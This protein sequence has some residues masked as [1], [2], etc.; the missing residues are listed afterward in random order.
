M[1][2]LNPY[3]NF[4]GTCEKAFNF[5]KSVFGGDFKGDIMRFGDINMEGMT[6]S[7]E[8][9]NLV[10]HISLPIGDEVLMG[11]DVFGAQSAGYRAGN[12]NYIS[13]SVDSREEADRLF[14]E[15]SAEGEVEMPMDDM[16]WGDY[17]GSFRDK[18]G[19]WWMI[20]CDTGRNME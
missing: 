3:L 7:D 8:E 19:I 16:F 11:S 9:R 4:N 2:K 15:L 17:Y 18:F 14:N 6:I 13:I 10:L 12:N 20:S 5:Y 1:V